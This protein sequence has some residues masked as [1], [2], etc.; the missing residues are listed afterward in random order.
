M[1]SLNSSRTRYIYHNTPQEIVYDVRSRDNSDIS[2]GGYDEITIRT[3][4]LL[5]N[6]ECHVVSASTC[7]YTML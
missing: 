7:I 1:K 5:S 6:I 3:A 4:S 2:K